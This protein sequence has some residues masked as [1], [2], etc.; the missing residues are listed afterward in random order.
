MTGWRLGFMI[1]SPEFI[2]KASETAFNVRSSLNSAVQ[3]AGAIALESDQRQ[4]GKMIA[5][6]ASRRDIM[7]GYLKQVNIDFTLPNRGFEIFPDFSS[8]G[9]RSSELATK[10]EKEI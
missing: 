1:S 8:F 2:D 7:S 9:M 4:V 5:E 3:Y 6:Y 10:M